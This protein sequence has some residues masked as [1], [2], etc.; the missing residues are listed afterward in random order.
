MYPQGQG[1]LTVVVL[2]ILTSGGFLSCLLLLQ[3]EASLGMGENVY[4]PVV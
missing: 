3:K 2:Y 4:L 1:V